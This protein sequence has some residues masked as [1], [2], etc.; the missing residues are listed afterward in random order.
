MR[1]Y[2]YKFFEKIPRFFKQSFD[3]YSTH[4]FGKELNIMRLTKL[5]IDKLALPS[6]MTNGK[7][8]QKRYCDDTLK[9]F[10]VRVTPGGTKAFFV[11]KLIANKLRRITV[12][13]YPALT[14]EQTR[15]EAQK[16]LGKIAM[17][18]ACFGKTSE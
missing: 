2:N 14:V 17:G 5:V 6:S 12:G 13:H 7:T 9:G 11:E 1:Y 15:K 10:G 3:T 4:F 16:L 8:A 18:I